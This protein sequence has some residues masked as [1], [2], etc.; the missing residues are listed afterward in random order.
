MRQNK[1]VILLLGEQ[2]WLK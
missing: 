2:D 1:A